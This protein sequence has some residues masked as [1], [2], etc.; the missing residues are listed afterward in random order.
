MSV[1]EVCVVNREASKKQVGHQHISFFLLFDFSLCFWNVDF[2]LTFTFKI[3]I[4][5]ILG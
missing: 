3:N 4:S 1:T 2:R 5:M